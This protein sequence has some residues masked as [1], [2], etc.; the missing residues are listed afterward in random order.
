MTLK[1]RLGS[2]EVIGNGTIRKLGYG[3][4]FAFHSKYG[5]ILQH[6]GDKARY[7]S[8]IDH[9]FFHIPLHSTPQLGG[10]RRNIAVLFGTEIPEWWGYLMVKYFGGVDRIPTCGGQTDGQTNRRT[11]RHFATA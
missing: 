10:L 5:S 3:F 8:K 7:S 9:D 1:S 11:D 2:L 6:F 4:L